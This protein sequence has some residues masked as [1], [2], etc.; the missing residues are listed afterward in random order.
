MTARKT[1]QEAAEAAETAILKNNV[2]MDMVKTV[3]DNG[4]TDDLPTL[5]NEDWQEDFIEA[6]ETMCVAHEKCLMHACE[7]AANGKPTEA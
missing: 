3:L 4:E 1:S 5:P 7:M 2:T 6:L